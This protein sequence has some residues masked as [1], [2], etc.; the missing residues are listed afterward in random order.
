LVFFTVKGVYSVLAEEETFLFFS[1]LRRSISDFKEILLSIRRK[2]LLAQY[3]VPT[4]LPVDA[5]EL[6]P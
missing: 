6:R 4:P 1:V 3:L 2:A 5:Q